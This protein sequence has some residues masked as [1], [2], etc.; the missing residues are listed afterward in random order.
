MKF[1]MTIVAAVLAASPAFAQDASKEPVDPQAYS[2]LWYEI[3]RTPAPFEQK[4][5]GG[6]TALYEVTDGGKVA[7]T[8]RCD[9]PGG[10]VSSVEGMAEPV[11]DGFRRLNVDFPKGPDEEGAN[12]VIE[13]VGPKDGGKYQWAAVR[14][15][16]EGIG[17]ILSRKPQIAN[18]VRAEAEQALQA[19]GID[20]QQLND[21]PQPPQNYEPQE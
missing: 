18:E 21:T 8:N 17:W 2:G 4:C 20:S 13:A 5:D 7:V 16:G 6:V 19:A 12:Y 14:G 10:E 9:L 3:A 15:S 1:H 11:G